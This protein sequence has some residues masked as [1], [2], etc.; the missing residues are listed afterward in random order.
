LADADPRNRADRDLILAA[1]REAGRIALAFRDKGV[2][3]WEKAKGDPV[4][5]ADLAADTYL[6]CALNP[7]GRTMAGCRRRPPTTSRV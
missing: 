1:A 3:A 7:S 4:S 5:E 6:Q 2:R